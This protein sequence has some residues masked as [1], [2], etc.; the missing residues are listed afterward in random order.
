[1]VQI[2][3][4]LGK[5][6]PRT[7]FQARYKK[8]KDLQLGKNFSSSLQI[9]NPFI[10]SSCFFTMVG[11]LRHAYLSTESKFPTTL[12]KKSQFTD[13]LIAYFHKSYLIMGPGFATQLIDYVYKECYLVTSCK[14]VSP[15][16]NSVLQICSLVW[17]ILLQPECRQT[18]LL[19][20]L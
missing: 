3:K 4:Y 14:N 12:P 19:K 17:V 9:I 8:R 10:D 20:T 16:L 7:I 1:M 15:V 11:S 6:N 18:G 5:E 13:L 2:F